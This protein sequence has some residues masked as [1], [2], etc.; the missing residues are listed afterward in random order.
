VRDRGAVISR[1]IDP[2]ESNAQPPVDRDHWS[3]L[4]F[5]KCAAATRAGIRSTIKRSPF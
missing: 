5:P 4:E 2:R 3:P 1:R